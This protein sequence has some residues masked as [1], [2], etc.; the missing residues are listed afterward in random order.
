MTAARRALLE[1][2]SLALA[3]TAA[4]CAS[5]IRVYVNPDAD[6]GFYRKVAVLPFTDIST[7]RDAGARVTRA[8]V[9]E[10]ILSN[11]YELIQPEDFLPTLVRQGVPRQ[12]DGTFDTEKLRGVATPLGVTGILRGAVTEYQMA[13]SNSGDI[14]I[15]AFDAELIDVA[16]GS[17][18]WRSS[19][20]RRGKGR[21]PVF[22]TSAR[23]LGKLTQDA[24]RVLVGRMKGRVL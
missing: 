17:V 16:T 4:S 6:L 13:R 19:I 24:C 1:V 5:S 22:G 3:M 21:V 11:R 10:L 12:S 18:V 2:V 15:I 23:S 8:F 20:V 14:P 9:T 7:T